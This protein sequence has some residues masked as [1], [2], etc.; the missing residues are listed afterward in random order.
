[1]R[2]PFDSN[3]ATGAAHERCARGGD[4]ARRPVRRRRLHGAGDPV[5]VPDPVD[6]QGTPFRG[7][8]VPQDRSGPALRHALRPHRHRRAL[9]QAAGRPARQRFHRPLPPALLRAERGPVHQGAGER[10]RRLPAHGDGPLALG[11]LVRARGLGHVRRPLRR[12]PFAAPHPHAAYLG[13]T[14]PAQGAPCPGHRDGSVRA[15]RRA[16]GPG[17]GGASFPPRGLGHEAHPRG[18]RLHVP[19]RRA[20]ASGHPR[21]HPHRPAAR[22]RGDRRLPAG[23]RLPPPGRGEDG[24]AAVLAL[25]HPLYGPHRLPWRGHE[26]PGLCPVGGAVGRHRRP[27][28]R[29]GDPRD[30]V[31]VLPH[32]Q[33]S[34]VVRHLRPGRGLPLDGLL[35]LQRPR[36]DLRHR[37]GGLRRTHAP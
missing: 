18:H 33:P 19:Q 3:G 25:L 35:H 23:D 28:S 5:R 36:A 8:Q 17:A 7:P 16:T 22:R 4:R 2:R 14:P 31:R 29:P 11:Q 13:G 32:R 30:D 6:V 10:R 15:S 37:P 27:R 20:P 24:G 1:M 21:G 34:R 9:P 26:Q 12:A